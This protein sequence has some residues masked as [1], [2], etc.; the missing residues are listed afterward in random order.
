MYELLDKFFL[1]FHSAVIVFNLFGW[2]WKKT[3]RA[4]LALLLLTGLSWFA[5]GLFY[6]IGYCPLT[7]W[8]WQV[9]HKLGRENIPN[10]Y[11]KYLLDRITGLDFNASLVDT[12]VTICFF[13]ALAASIFVNARDFKRSRRAAQT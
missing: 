5:L 6:G 3:R 4:N 11:V 1:V 8:H 7:D 2:M 10:S 9:L 13:A 12:S